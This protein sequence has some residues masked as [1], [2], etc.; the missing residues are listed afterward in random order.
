[1]APA[2]GHSTRINPKDGLLYVWIPAG[3]FR[4][5]CSAGDNA[6]F[7]W[8]LPGRSVTINRGFWIGATEVTQ[9]AY[10]RVTGSDPS[11]YRGDRLP[12]DRVSWHDARKYCQAVAMRLPSE[13]EWEYAARGRTVAARYGPLEEIAWYAGNS[14]DSTHEVGSKRPNAFGLYDTLGNVWEWVE[15]AY[16]KAPDKRILRGDS[17]YNLAPHVRVSDRLWATPDTAHRDMGF[18]CVGD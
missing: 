15:D 16:E 14:A 10:R 8:E 12:V 11:L 7:A 4:M 5:G 6:C 3:K 9:D 1:M 17:F 18:R 2:L 13:A